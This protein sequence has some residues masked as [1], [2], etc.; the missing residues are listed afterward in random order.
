VQTA[1]ESGATCANYVRVREFIKESGRVAGVVADD[2]E[3]GREIRLRAK[4]VINATGPFSDYLR[5]LDE[6]ESSSAIVPSQGIHLVFDRSFMPG[7][8]A[9]I[10]PKTRDDRVIFAIPWHEHTMVG[11]TDTEL[12]DA[13]LDPQPR[14]EEIE[15]LLETIAP[16]WTR[17]PQRKD[18]RAIF[19]GIRPL[20]RSGDAKNTS[21][22]A[23]D[24]LIRVS[25]SGLISIMGGKWTTYRRMAED[26]V[27]RAMEVGGLLPTPC[28]TKTL[29][30]HGADGEPLGGTLAYYGSD[31]AAIQQLADS[32]PELQEPLA[33]RLPHAAAQVVWAARHEMARSVEDVLA[34]RVRA[35]FYDAEA[36]VQAAPKVA[37]LLAAELGRD[38]AW[39]TEQLAQFGKIA[40][41]YCCQINGR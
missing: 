8:T 7:D 11:T 32:Q 5:Q 41:L 36:A 23:R 18:V 14:P 35:L 38:E 40:E 12:D 9:L 10:V 39:Q 28:R 27:D 19:A 29:P 1:I 2:V 22:L 34:R 15:F 4:A 26:G 31:G 20:A 6:P 3:S 33:D 13:T 37:A 16:Y 30:I 17:K 25:S 21:K 24:H